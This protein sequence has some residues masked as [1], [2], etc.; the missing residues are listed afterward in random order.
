MPVYHTGSLFRELRSSGNFMTLIMFLLFATF[1]KTE[2]GVFRFLEN[3]DKRS[4]YFP[5]DN[6]KER[7][8]SI[9]SYDESADF[10]FIVGFC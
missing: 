7:R 3:I 4:K 8:L 6:I 9:S 2:A 1:S 10:W 5:P